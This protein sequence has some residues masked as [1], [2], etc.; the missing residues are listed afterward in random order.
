MYWPDQRPA[1]HINFFAAQFVHHLLNPGLHA[2]AGAN[3]VNFPLNTVDRHLGARSNG[4]R[5]WVG[6]TGNGHD[7]HRPFL[8]LGDFVF[9]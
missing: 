3:R 2:N 6:F 8:D 5:R 7:P 4:S 9:K 1:D